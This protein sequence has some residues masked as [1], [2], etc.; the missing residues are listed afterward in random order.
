MYYYGSGTLIDDLCRF[1]LDVK[2]VK[3]LLHVEHSNHVVYKEHFAFLGHQMLAHISKE[4]MS[5]LLKNDILL[6]LDFA[7]WD[8]CLDCRKG[9]QTNYISKNLATKSS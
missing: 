7:D 3:S 4:R 1:N 9:K 8:V 5:R 6:Q 2:F